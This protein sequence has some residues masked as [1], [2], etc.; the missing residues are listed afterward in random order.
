MNKKS[1]AL[2]ITIWVISSLSVLAVAIGYWVSLGLRLTAYQRDRLKACYMAK[3]GINRA[4]N[5]IINDT[6]ISYDSLT[7]DWADDEKA[8]KK[9][10]LNDN[11]GEFASVRYNIIDG[12]NEA[13]SVYGLIDEERKVNINFA[14]QE[15]LAALLEEAGIDWKQQDIINNILIWRGDIPDTNRI[16]ENSGYPCKAGK[17]QNVEE[18]ILVKGINPEDIEKLRKNITVYT[19]GLININTVS[20]ETLE[21]VLRGI[22]KRLILESVFA[23]SLAKKIIV[24]RNEFG[25]F[26]ENNDIKV[27]TTGSEEVNIFNDLLKNIVFKSDNFLIAASGSVNK[28]NREV[29]AVYDRKQKLIKYWHET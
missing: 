21:I 27:A 9:I 29:E 18:L 1:Q 11:S 16:Y 26:R 5:V 13:K 4:I 7:E 19:D 24:L 15:L 25:Y 12:N 2:V 22:A 17:M 6:T 8:F 20:L 14:S 10:S 3:A 28:I 23:D